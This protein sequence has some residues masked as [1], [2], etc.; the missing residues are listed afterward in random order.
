MKTAAACM[1]VLAGM[2]GAFAQSGEARFIEVRGTVEVQDEGAPE[3]RA[4]FPGDAIG[5]NTV[6]STGFKSSALIA[7]GDSRLSVR[8]LTRLALEELARRDGAEEASLYLRTGRVRAEVRA[9]AGLRADFTVRSPIA[10]ASVRGTSFEFGGGHLYVES[11][12]V[13]LEGAGGQAVYAQAGERSYVDEAEQ[14]IIPPYEAEVLRPV[15]SEL[16]GSTGGGAPR[17]NA[18]GEDAPPLGITADWR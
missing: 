18:P 14:R 6:I 5:K 13:L 10:T 9:P 12:R 11:G 7:L 16:A 17:L 8:P 15:L 4:V 2:C 1:L 3:W